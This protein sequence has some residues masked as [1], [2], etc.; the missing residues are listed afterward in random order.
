MSSHAVRIPGGI[1]HFRRTD[2]YFI[3]NGVR[4]Y[5]DFH[6]Y[7]GPDFSYDKHGEKQC[8]FEDIPE[9]VWDKF[10]KWFSKQRR[11]NRPGFSEVI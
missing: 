5:C 3:H 4:F 8:K 2:T 7:L 10:G 1:A 6:H 11:A 9:A